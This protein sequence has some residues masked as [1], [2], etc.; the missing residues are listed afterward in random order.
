MSLK[1]LI[2]QIRKNSFKVIIRQKKLGNNRRT[3]E[4]R[5]QITA[6]LKGRKG[7][8]IITDY[9]YRNILYAACLLTWLLP[10]FKWIQ[11][12]LNKS[13]LT[14]PQLRKQSCNLGIG[15]LICIVEMKNADKDNQL[16]KTHCCHL[17]ITRTYNVVGLLDYC[18]FYCPPNKLK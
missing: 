11:T 2:Y 1:R 8:I 14:K 4:I 7:I 15:N 9:L 13:F 18:H 3:V 6:T 16:E 5:L 10:F 17:I 12:N